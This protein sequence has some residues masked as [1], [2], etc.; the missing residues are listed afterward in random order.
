MKSVRL[1]P[2]LARQLRAATRLLDLSDSEFIRQ[3]VAARCAEV[4][5][6]TLDRRLQDYVG[7]LS[8]GGGMAQHTGRAFA[9]LLIQRTHEQRRR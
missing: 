7:A 1:D 9:D 5:G 3:A 2:D 8:L 4:L 6:N